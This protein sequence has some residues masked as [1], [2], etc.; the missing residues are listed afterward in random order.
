M[1]RL[2]VMLSLFVVPIVIASECDVMVIEVI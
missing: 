2:V 1:T